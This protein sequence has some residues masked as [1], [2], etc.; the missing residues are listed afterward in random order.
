MPQLL[1]HDAGREGQ[2]HIQGSER[3]KG[4]RCWDEIVP[5]VN[6]ELRKGFEEEKVREEI[7]RKIC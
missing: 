5:F 7:Q 6:G 1:I 2:G 3:A 4:L